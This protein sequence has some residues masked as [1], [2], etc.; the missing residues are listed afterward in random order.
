MWVSQE[1]T[2]YGVLSWDT[3]KN[4]IVQ[5]LDQFTILRTDLKCTYEHICVSGL[6]LRL[7]NLISNIIS[8]WWS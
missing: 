2:K 1:E 8:S 3:D 5:F 6:Y 4:N 7:W